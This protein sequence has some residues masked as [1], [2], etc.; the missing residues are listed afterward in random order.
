MRWPLKWCLLVRRGLLMPVRS[1]REELSPSTY[2][3]ERK[4]QIEAAARIQYAYRTPSFL[5]RPAVDGKNVSEL[6]GDLNS[7]AR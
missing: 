5:L 3:A 7:D 4:T 2:S 6:R 1:K